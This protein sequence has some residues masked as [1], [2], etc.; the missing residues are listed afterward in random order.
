MRGMESG[1]AEFSALCLLSRAISCFRGSIYPGCLHM[2]Q[3]KSD[4]LSVY[5]GP[6]KP[7]PKELSL[8]LASDRPTQ[9]IATLHVGLVC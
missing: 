8:P 7:E 4:K 5:Q 1:A 9:T 6:V 2:I 3:S